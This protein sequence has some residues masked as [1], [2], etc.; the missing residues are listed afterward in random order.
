MENFLNNI[1]TTSNGHR[2]VCWGIVLIVLTNAMQT[3]VESNDR[4]CKMKVEYTAVGKAFCYGM[5]AL[6]IFMSVDVF[7]FQADY[8]ELGFFNYFAFLFS[9]IETID[10]LC[11]V[12]INPGLFFIVRK[13]KGWA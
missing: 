6:I 11:K 10:N 3:I 5:F 7:N 2:L 12:F 1:M 9:V 8:S 4:E 13:Y